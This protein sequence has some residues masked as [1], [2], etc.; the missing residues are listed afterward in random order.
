MLAMGCSPQQVAARLKVFLP[1]R[2]ERHVSHESIYLA[3]YAYP[4]GELKRQL[5]AYLRQGKG[6][7]ATLLNR[8]S[9]TAPKRS[10]G[11]R[12]QPTGKAT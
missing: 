8:T 4:R 2:P 3:I 7:R 1:D 9:V 5:I 10:K 12:S 6:K 11:G